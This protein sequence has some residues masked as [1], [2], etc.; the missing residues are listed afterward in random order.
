MTDGTHP[1]RIEW[2]TEEVPGGDAALVAAVMGALY[3]GFTALS[4]LVGVTLTGL[5]SGLQ[6]ITFFAAVYALAALAL[7][8]Q[9]GYAGLFNV[10]V[11]GFMAVGVYTMAI[12]TRPV[13]PDTGVGGF[14]L[15]LVVGVLGGIA[16]A[17]LLGFVAAVP[18]LRVRDDYLAI[19]TVGLG[20][21]VRLT[22]N[23]QTFA[24]VD[25]FGVTT[26]TGGA[27][28]LSLPQNPV[29]AL[30][31]VNPDSPA[32]GAT[33]LGDALFGVASSVGIPNAVALS[34]A[35]TLVVVGFVGLFYVY[36][37][38]LANSPFG[39][40]LKA[41]R[42]DEM[43]AEALGKDTNRFKITAFVVGCALMGLTGILWQGSQGF[44]SPAN[45]LPQQ[46]F[47]IFIALII[48][49]AGSNTG[50]VLGGALFAGLL[51]RG[52]PLLAN[53]VEAFA[54]FGRAPTT[55]ID[56]VI[57]LASAD[58]FPLLAFLFDHIA[59]LRFMLVGAV[60]IYLI[61]NRP[62]GLLGHRKETASTVSLARGGTDEQ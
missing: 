12:L 36:L 58:P 60:L 18:A 40:V 31:Y 9:W 1:S 2:F 55:V 62:Q 24:R 4:L 38:R 29:D 44:T 25:V 22:V 11:A 59:A 6:G 3:V 7:N 45:Y 33:I 47:Y 20:E 26:G 17:A 53:T 37:A 35:Y 46:T 43:V 51:F 48:G 13:N 14:G 57:P 34:W 56:A 61:Q 52:P 10:G 27:N 39:R 54:D 32:E 15:P 28:G 16:I 21:I 50:S 42:E 49:G 5:V 8:L 23:S 41:I 30:F 19:I